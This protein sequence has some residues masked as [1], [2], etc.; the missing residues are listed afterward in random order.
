MENDARN[1]YPMGRQWD[2]NRVIA[3]TNARIAGRNI[4]IKSCASFVVGYANC[5]KIKISNKI[6]LPLNERYA[7]KEKA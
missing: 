1:V 5:S 4:P 3:D 7:G 6:L 2:I